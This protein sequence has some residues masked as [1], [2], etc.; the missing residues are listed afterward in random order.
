VT[1]GEDGEALVDLMVASSLVVLLT[2]VLV[3]L[4]GV[5]EVGLRATSS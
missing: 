3:L 5:S 4:L 2:A 1:R